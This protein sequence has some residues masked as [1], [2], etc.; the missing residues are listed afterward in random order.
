MDSELQDWEL[1]QSSNSDLDRVSPKRNLEGIEGD[2]EGMIRSDY[3]SLDNQSRY[4]KTVAVEGDVSEEGSVE[5]DNP[6]WIDPGSETRYERK[7][8]GGFWF[9]S[10]TRYERKNLGGFWFDSETRYER[11]NLGG[12]RCVKRARL[13]HISI[14]R[15]KKRHAGMS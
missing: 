14:Q 5:S 1:L 13:V 9:D 6:S 12:F 4:A 15:V 2:T 3:F 11:K 7:N 8:L 10:E